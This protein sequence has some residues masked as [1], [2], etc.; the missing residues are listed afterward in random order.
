MITSKS[1]ADLKEVLMDPKNPGIKEPYFVIHG[2]SEENITVLSP[3]K[4]GIEFNKTFGHFHNY[5]GVEIYHCLFGQGVLLL[6]RNDETGEAKEFRIISLR[7]GITAEIPAGYGH[8]LV[9][10]GKHFLIVVDNAPNNPKAH[11]Y[12]TV[13]NKKGLAYYIVDKQGDISFEENPS[14]KYHPQITS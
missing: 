3:G 14:Y 11:D 10:T 8:A 7:P 1:R 13:K 6:Q 2:E 12:E 4:N 9:N 5:N